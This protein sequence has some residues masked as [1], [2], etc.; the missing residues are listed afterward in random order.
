[1]TTTPKDILFDEEAR[2]KLLSGIN[3]LA[4]V[5][6][7]TL[8]PK[9]RN[10]GMEK[11]WGAPQITNDGSTI[12]KEIDLEGFEN[13]GV[14]IAKEVVQKIKEKA[15]DG[16]T[17]GIV[18]LRALVEAG[19]KHIASGASPILLKR[20][21][22]K[23]IDTAL[24]SIDELS[25]EIKTDAEIRSIA[26]VSAS[27]NAEVGNLIADAMEKVGRKGVITLEEAKGIDTTIEVVEGMQFD[28]GYLSPYFCTNADKLIVEMSGAQILLVDKK[29]SSVHELLPILQAT[30]ASG[31]ELLIV[32]EEID[33]DALSTLVVNKLRGV[34][35][36]CAVKAPGFGDRR[37]AMLQDIAVLTGATVVSEETGGSLKDA[38]PDVLGS[39]EKITISKDKTTLIASGHDE[40]VKQRIAQIDAEIARTES[41]YD[42]EKLEERKAKLAGGVAVIRIGAATEPEMKQ[43]K[44]IAEDSLNS[45]RAAVEEGIVPGGGVALLRAISALK[46]LKLSGDEHLGLLLVTHALKAPV[47]QIVNNSGADGS[48]VV[49]ELLEEKPSTGF[50]ALTGTKEDLY[51]AGVID[52]SKVVKS[53]LTHAAS[54]AGIVLLSEALVID[55]KE[56]E[57]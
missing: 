4:D 12:V 13:L 47:T 28:R 25:R 16:T 41:T 2:E 50:N 57:E 29:I 48:V 56:D 21:M 24:K 14:S 53:A 8:G 36:V 54:A 35:K 42:V 52:P 19:V 34:L 22:D 3:Q 1:M 26:T 51:K 20:G 9:G 30:A 6:A 55:A 17:T 31:G 27:G 18:L 32:A 7:F 23:A 46:G 37:K 15:G 44:Q 39:A 43:K 11:S 45:T 5:V 38:S 40:A 10:V 33:G 49:A